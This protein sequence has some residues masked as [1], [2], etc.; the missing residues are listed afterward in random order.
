MEPNDEIDFCNLGRD[1]IV[2]DELR[3]HSKPDT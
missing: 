3:Q 2:P 1:F